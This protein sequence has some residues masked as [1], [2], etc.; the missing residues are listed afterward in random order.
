[1]AVY[2]TSDF[3]FGHDREFIWKVR[4][5]ENL[6]AMEQDYIKKYNSIVNQDDDVYILGDLMLGPNSERTLELIRQLNGKLHLVRGNHD[7][8]TRWKRYEELPNVVSMTE[9]QFLKYGKYHFYL[10]HFPC[11][12]GNLEK[13]SLKQMT[14]NL[15][16]HT[17]QKSN[18]YNDIPYMYHVGVDS[19]DGYPVAADTIIK[20]MYEKMEECKSFL[21]EPEESQEFATTE[22]RERLK[23]AYYDLNQ[24]LKQDDF[25]N[26][27]QLN[28][29]W[30]R[31]KRCTWYQ[32]DCPGYLEKD[33][34][35]S[36]C[37]RYKRDPPDGG[38]YG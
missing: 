36:G 7:T 8:D 10:S 34:C 19:H 25:Q 3:H 12:T 1:M 38:Y 26:A 9:G 30:K 29:I 32:V 31:C 18:F 13:E 33:G 37:N 5:Y 28:Q 2:F 6:E 17:H 24:K 15:Y 21:D 27:L 14:L 11:M 16:G 20:E 35:P 4:G 23:K 22:Y